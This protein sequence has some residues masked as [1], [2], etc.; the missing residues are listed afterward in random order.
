MKN[1]TKNAIIFAIEISV[2]AI[3]FTLFALSH[4]FKISSKTANLIYIVFMIFSFG[5]L[6]AYEFIFKKYDNAVHFK[7]FDKH[8]VPAK[9][10]MPDKKYKRKGIGG[11]IVLWAA[12]LLVL[13]VAKFIGFMTW[14]LFLMGAC[15][16][17]MLNS[18]F[19][20]KKCLLSVLFLH[21]KNDC[22]KNCAINCW[23]YSIFSSALIF[24]PNM[25]IAAGIVNG[26]IITASVI[27]LIMWEYNFRKHPYRFYPE[28]NKSLGCQNCLKQCKYKD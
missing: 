13:A 6:F 26:V 14:R 24:A 7:M 10:K 11:V 12:Y 16:M 1:K 18:F 2:Y 25:G 28:T 17:F 21:N 20:R 15:V 23:D 3:L 8:Y 22:C 5:W 9:Q 27:M 19:V 4:L